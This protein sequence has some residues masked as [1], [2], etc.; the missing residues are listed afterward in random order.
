MTRLLRAI[1]NIKFPLAPRE[2]GRDIMAI[3]QSGLEAV[4]M[5]NRMESK[6]ALA[7]K[8]SLYVGTGDTTTVT[9]SDNSTVSI[10]ETVAFNP[11]EIDGGVMIRDTSESNTTGW[12][13]DK[14]GKDNIKDA[15]ITPEKLDSTKEYSVKNI[16]ASE[17]SQN[18]TRTASFE[19]DSIKYSDGGSHNGVLQF[20]QRS[21]KD[22]G[23]I[24]ATTDDLPPVFVYYSMIDVG[25]NEHP[26]TATAASQEVTILGMNNFVTASGGVTIGSRN[27]VR[28][29]HN[30][31]I[32]YGCNQYNDD[33]FGNS[34][35]EKNVIIGYNA[36]ANTLNSINRTAN[37]NIDIGT[38]TSGPPD[39]AV[40]H[41]GCGD[42]HYTGRALYLGAGVTGFTYMNAPGSSWTSAS[43]IRDKAEIKEVEHALDFIEKLKP[44]TYVMNDRER[45][46][47]KD[48][49]DNPILDKNGKQQYD[50][51]A[52]KR[53][54]K[55]KHRRFVGLS[56]QDTYQA[57]L[58]C[59]DGDSNYAQIVDNNRFDHP[60]D[61][62]IE[63][64]SIS[65]ERLVPFLIKAMQEQQTQIEEQQRQ[66]QE[67]N[68]KFS[69]QEIKP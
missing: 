36:G 26:S 12:A 44:I 40:T 8:G 37:H 39:A 18:L 59:Y 20:P 32:G 15:A 42:Y 9:K 34:D 16:T 55:K 22:G 38:G 47:I 13:V 23:E 45:Y 1:N 51:E 53:G 27:N 43:D 64:Y 63:Q 67:L 50:V 58:E 28:G 11:P 61:E 49:D 4:E 56:A 5:R 25:K 60:E 10:P 48:E 21:T 68:S 17:S 46:L 66:I 30:V 24:L 14:V 65:Y 3:I 52:H 7:A 35:S 57:M 2:G 54:E 69:N 29:T 41:I 33:R 31:V 19:C 6:E 62:H